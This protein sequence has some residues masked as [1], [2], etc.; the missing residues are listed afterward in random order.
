[1]LI[2][3]TE[4]KNKFIK[5]IFLLVI[6]IFP[7]IKISIKGKKINGEIKNKLVGDVDFS[8]VKE[9]VFAISPVP[10]GVGPMTIACLL[11]NTTTAFK[12]KISKNY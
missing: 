1:M 9:K 2:N 10:G 7:V 11:I 4:I 8:Q 5:I 6:L 3:R 12:N